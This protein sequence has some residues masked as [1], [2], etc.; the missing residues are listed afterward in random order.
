ML[1]IPDFI[2]SQ[3]GKSIYFLIIS[4]NQFIKHEQKRI[5]KFPDTVFEKWL[6]ST[7]HV[8]LAQIGQNAKGLDLN[9]VLFFA[10]LKNLRIFILFIVTDRIYT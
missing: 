6:F 10:A 8:N 2:P 1:S 5:S 4:T 9:K 7:S 3:S